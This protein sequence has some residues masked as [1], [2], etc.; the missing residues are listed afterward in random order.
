MAHELVVKENPDKYQLDYADNIGAVVTTPANQRLIIPD[1]FLGRWYVRAHFKPMDATSTGRAWFLQRD[2]LAF[3]FPTHMVHPPKEY[4]TLGVARM[5]ISNCA[6]WLDMGLGKTFVTLS[7][8]MHVYE[9]RLGNTFLILCPLSCFITWEDEIKKHVNPNVNPNIIFAHGAK[10]KKL[11]QN[12][13]INTPD[14]PTFLITTYES[15]AS[16]NTE[17]MPLNIHSVI[18]DESSKIAGFNT[19]RTQAIFALSRAKPQMRRYEL[20]GTPSTTSPIGFYS[21]YEFL[22][23]DWS[24]DKSLTEFRNRYTSTLLFMRVKINA[25][26]DVHVPCEPEGASER[27]LAEHYPE[28]MPETNYLA[29][30]YKFGRRPG[31]KKLLIINHYRRT[32]SHKNL[33]LLRSIT[34]KVAYTLKKADVLTNLPEK[35]FVRRQIKLTIE[36]RR[37]YGRLDNKENVELGDVHIDFHDRSSP[38]AKLHQIANGLLM[39]DGMVDL[40]T[41]NPKIDE[42]LQI[43]EEAGDQKLIIWIPYPTLIEHLAELLRKNSVR[44]VTIHGAVPSKKRMERIQS[45]QHPNGPQILIA[46]PEV[47]GLGL[48]LTICSLAVFF[49]NWWIPA[50]RKQAIDRIHRIGQTRDCTIIDLVAS[51]TLESEILRRMNLSTQ[52]EEEIMKPKETR[53]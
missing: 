41:K 52:I 38:H 15:L 39:K 9:Q 17:L 45:Y 12:L 4:Q 16:I 32:L 47:A 23:D 33:H 30:G 3:T 42:I 34:S 28:G 21:Q 49:A 40:A 25:N 6:L 14:K 26:K 44:S 22:G 7:Y 43:L 37:L 48:N 2:P 50:T 24:G 5:R 36:Q 53:A 19:Q 35:Y 13:R 51:N 1:S 27:W 8:C 46:N 20:S 11:L 18:C 10:R 31:T 29:E